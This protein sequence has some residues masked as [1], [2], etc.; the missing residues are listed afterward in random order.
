[1]PF[2]QGLV[3]SGPRPWPVPPAAVAAKKEKG[4]GRDESQVG[5]E[6]LSTDPG[7]DSQRNRQE[8]RRLTV[9]KR[10]KYQA[11]FPV[12]TLGGASWVMRGSRQRTQNDACER[13]TPVAITKAARGP[14]SGS[15][16]AL[17]R[18]C[19]SPD[20]RDAWAATVQGGVARRTVYGSPPQGWRAGGRTQGRGAKLGLQRVNRDHK[21]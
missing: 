17:V 20:R 12:D 13:R 1:M 16:Q 10:K 6:A 3:V 21:G 5:Q 14:A 15:A 8:K 18:A 7:R 11:Q 2:A 4:C 19:C 9:A